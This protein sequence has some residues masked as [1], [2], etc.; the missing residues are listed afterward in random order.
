MRK[1][2]MIFLLLWHQLQAAAYRKR[3]V[4]GYLLGIASVL[5]TSMNYYRFLGTHSG[6]LWEAFIVHFGTLGN[7]SLI[8]FGFII[9]MS[10]APFIYSDSFLKIHRAGRKNWYDAMWSYIVTQGFFYYFIMTLASAVVLIKKTYFHNIWSQALQD[11]AGSLGFRNHIAIPS[12]LLFSQYSPWSAMAHTFLLIV[13]YSILL[14]GIL[15]ALNMYSNTAFGTIAAGMIHIVSIL[16]PSLEQFTF[17]RPWLHLDNALLETHL[18]EGG[19]TLAHSYIYFILSIY[20]VYLL[21]RF[22]VVHTDFQMM[23]SSE[24][25]E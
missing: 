11:Y 20:V 7:T 3:C 5:I 17:L 9:V 2:K 24:G 19:F 13:L 21:G 14:A 8:V 12:P 22:V 16:I 6:N 25:N 18:G 15:F 1:F 10:D 4:A 23:G